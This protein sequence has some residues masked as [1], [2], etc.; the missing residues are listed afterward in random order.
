MVDSSLFDAFRRSREFYEDYALFM[1]RF[2]VSGLRRLGVECACETLNLGVV[3][4][5][6][7]LAL[8]SSA[9]QM[10]DENDW[11]K[12]TDLAVTFLDRYGA[13]VGQRGIMHDDAVPLEQYPDYVIKAVLATE[14]RR[15]FEHF[16]QL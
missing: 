10:T 13:K 7:M 14:D 12:Q 11:L 15:F 16:G 5:I 2:N 8:A 6:G 1:E 9:F 4:L 3:G